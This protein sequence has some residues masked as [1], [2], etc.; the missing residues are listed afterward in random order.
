MR[1]GFLQHLSLSVLCAVAVPACNISNPAP[2]APVNDAGDFVVSYAD[3]V[4]TVLSAGNLTSC[5]TV[6]PNCV[7]ATA[8]NPACSG[9]AFAALAAPD[10]NVFDL[11]A[12]DRLVVAFYCSQILETGGASS[13]TTDFEIYGALNGGA[14][15]TVE[16]SSDATNYR[17]V[18]L[19][20][21][22]GAGDGGIT[23]AGFQLEVAQV[24][25][26]RYVRIS[27]TGAGVI[28]VDAVESLRS[29]PRTTQ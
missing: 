12:N 18:N 28:H 13:A 11:A 27:N 6:F 29:L 9:D 25:Y 21:G 2:N 3:Q 22:S 15:G 8:Q 17:T 1:P 14:V 20:V 5:G 19:W 4:V 26:A 10:G 23:P 16:V 7:E 24:T